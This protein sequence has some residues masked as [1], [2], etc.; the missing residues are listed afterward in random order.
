MT[1]TDLLSVLCNRLTGDY[2]TAAHV[3]ELAPEGFRETT[4]L[5]QLLPILEEACRIAEHAELL[6]ALT[7]D[8]DDLRDAD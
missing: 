7:D 5:E 3:L 1:F 6:S 2:L 4:E 8:L